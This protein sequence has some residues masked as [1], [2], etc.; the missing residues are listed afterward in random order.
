M[1]ELTATTFAAALEDYY[2]PERLAKLTYADRPTL[3]VIPKDEKWTGAKY[4]MPMMYVAPQGRSAAFA[5]AQANTTAGGYERWELTTVQDYGVVHI[6]TEAILASEGQP[7][8]YYVQARTSEIDGIIGSLASSASKSLFR[9]GGGAIG[10]RSGALSGDVLTL[11]NVEDIVNF[12]KGQKLKASTADGTSGSLRAGTAAVVDSVDRDAGTI[13]STT[14]GNITSFAA[15][16]YLFVEGDFGAK[17]KGFEAWCPA[18][19]PSSTSFFGV[20]RSVDVTRLGGIRYSDS[21]PI[22][23]KIKRAC[24]RARREEAVIDLGI[25]NPVQWAELEIALDER[26]KIETVKSADGAFG[27]EALILRTPTGTVKF[28]ADPDCPPDVCWLLQKNT[29]KLC[30]RGGVPRRIN[31]DGN[32]LLRQGTS[33]GV[34]G[35]FGYYAQLGCSMPGRNVRVTLSTS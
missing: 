20:D 8:R 32:E 11:S 25:L 12:E 35:R 13:T 31:I 2:S 29:W 15:D 14:W 27:F 18:S 28:L 19:A 34:E 23:E 22:I 4:I 17:L 21:N 30:S 6:S 1:T 3:A 16:D 33:D 7:A 10:R 24:A 9:N 26:S 5:T